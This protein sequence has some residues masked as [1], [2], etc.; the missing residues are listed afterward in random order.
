[1]KKSLA[2]AFLFIYFIHPGFTQKKAGS[3]GPHLSISWELSENNYK[4]KG[5]M[6]SLLTISNKGTKKLPASGWSIYFNGAIPHNADADTSMTLVEMVNGDFVKLHPLTSFKGIPANSSLTVKLLS[7]ELKNIT[8]FPK[9]FYI[10]FDNDPS[11]GIAIHS[12]NKSLIDDEKR[13]KLL[14]E[15]QYRQNVGVNDLPEGQLIPVF[16][17]PASYTRTSGFFNL[18]AQVKIT[19]GNDFVKEAAYLSE[20]IAKATGIKPLVTNNKTGNLI[21]LQK[22]ELKGDEAYEL[23]VSPGKIV[24][25]AAGNAGIFY[26]IQSLKVLL[27]ANSWG[28]KQASVKIPGLE[29]KDNPRYAYRAFMMD[30]ARN[31]QQKKEIIKVI[32]LISFYKINVLHLHLNDDEGWRIEIPGLPELTSVGGQRG[33]TLDEKNSLYPSY[34]S[35]PEVGKTSGSGFLSKADY[36]EI[37]KYATVRH[38]KV[39]PE[40]ESPGHARAAIKSMNARYSRLMASGKTEDAKKYLLVDLNDQSV[41]RSVQGWSDNVINPALPSVYQFL[42]KVTDEVI[43]MYKEAGAPLQTIHFGGDEVP[44]GVWEKSPAVTALL[45]QDPS[46]NGVDDLWYYYFNK[47]NLMLKQRGLYLSAW[48]E[49][50]LKKAT[51]DGRKK[52]VLDTRLS[53][54]NLHT[55]VW[56]NIGGN[57]DLAYK[58]ANAGYKVVLTNV[59]NLYLD[60]SYNDSYAEPGQYWGGHVDVDKPFSFIPLDYYKNQKENER[61]Q[62]LSM[63][64]FKDKERLTEFGK[65]NIVGIQAPLWSEIITTPARFEYLMLPKLFGLAERSWAADPAWATEQDTVKAE[66]FYQ[67][68]WSDFVNILGKRELSRLNHYAGGFGYRIP[69][70]GF[71]TQDGRV[72]VNVQY[73][74]LIIRYTEDGSE[75]TVT[76]KLYT[77]DLPETANLSF[78]VFNSLGRGGNTVKYI[79]N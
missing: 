61:G 52:M 44:A 43:A 50:G 32:D 29:I 63:D 6:L 10:V 53:N 70:V 33:H 18:N 79:R 67:Q 64:Y 14:A 16:P 28:K 30:L 22:K 27:P 34:G 2:L 20:E 74:G 75:P 60:L 78:R 57:E 40:F 11:Q 69:T 66:E 42:Q 45:Q 59:T 35:G 17:S 31:F 21:M 49:T 51:V 37:L 9:G 46:I 41:Y 13:D 23:S 3:D 39:I 76:S 7:R 5:E 58:L 47:V 19:G 71:I 12:E 24:I 56:N 54:E 8:D 77:A 62:P 26:G 25:S 1:M 73:P 72:K 65:S 55:E 36:I 4:G 15:K 38:V 68:S 48:E